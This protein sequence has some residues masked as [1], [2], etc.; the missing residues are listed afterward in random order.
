MRGAVVVGLANAK[1]IDGRVPPFEGGHLIL[2]QT[3]TYAH[4]APDYLNDAVPL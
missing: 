2:H 3:M 4:F 1:S